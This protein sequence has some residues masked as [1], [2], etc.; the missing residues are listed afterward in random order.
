[1]HLHIVQVTKK[2]EEQNRENFIF[3]VFAQENRVKN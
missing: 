2:I 1:M 3:Y